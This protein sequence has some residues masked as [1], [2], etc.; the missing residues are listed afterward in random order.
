MG[1]DIDKPALMSEQT[2]RD[3][4]LDLMKRCLVNIIYGRYETGFRREHREDCT[5]IEGHPGT[6]ASVWPTMAHTMMGMRRLRNIQACAETAFRCRVPG[7]LIETGIWRGGGVI[8]MRAILKAQGITDRAV[9]AADSF[10]GVP[11][12][13]GRHPEDKGDRHHTFLELKVPLDEVKRN[14]EVY[15][16]LD[17]QVRFLPG[18]FRDTLPAA[19][20]ERIALLRLDGD[21]YGSTMDALENLYPKVSAGGFVIVDDWNLRGAQKAVKDYRA[22]HGSVEELQ[23]VDRFAVYW[24]KAS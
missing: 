7:D 9:W 19:P 3:L 1:E 14:F 16:L 4:Y 21:L 8:F 6:G 5:R 20:I 17:D 18:L 24:R 23:E 15:G 11:A 2:L 22:A 12:P 13:D 10:A